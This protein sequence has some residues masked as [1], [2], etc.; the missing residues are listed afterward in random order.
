MNKL[1]K[2]ALISG[3]VVV[4][5]G[6]ALSIKSAG[7]NDPKA[8][9]VDSPIVQ[10]LE[11]HEQR[12]GAAEGNIKSLQDNTTVSATPPSTQTNSDNSNV[13]VSPAVPS[14]ITEPKPSPVFVT[15]FEQIPV[16]ENNTD[17][18]YTYSD[19]TFYTFRWKVI[20]PQGAWVTDGFGQNGHWSKT[21]SISGTCNNESLGQQKPN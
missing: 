12:L 9:A 1:C 19:G 2:I 4:V 11:N 7:N 13:I 6:L 16:D 3:S 20:N 14:V 5:S 18:K 8:T 10:Q 15:N 17:C 21:T